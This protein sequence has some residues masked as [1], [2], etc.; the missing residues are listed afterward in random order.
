MYLLPAG[1]EAEGFVFLYAG[2]DEVGGPVYGAVSAGTA[3][4]EADDP[5]DLGGVFFIRRRVF[6][7][8]WLSL[9][10]GR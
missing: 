7:I 5:L 6:A 10:R 2:E 4:G 9:L 8:Q 1:Q 3:V